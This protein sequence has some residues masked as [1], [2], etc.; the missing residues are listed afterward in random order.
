MR[1]LDAFNHFF[2]DRFYKTML[3]LAPAHKDMGKR[4][5]NIPLLHDLEARFRVMD[6]FDDYAQ[7][8]S[9]PSP[10]LEAFAAPRDAIELARIGN[11]G[12]ADLVRRHP[13]RFPAFVASLPMS[14]P[15]AALV[16]AQRAL[17]DLGACGIQVFTNV[18]G[19]PLTAPPFLPLFDLM[20]E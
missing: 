7:I 11:D 20:A 5:R 18:N 9:L 4:I 13:D 19:A 17:H 12:L 2:P 10:P 8:L 1:K 6:A 3:A 15:E 14:D 16:E